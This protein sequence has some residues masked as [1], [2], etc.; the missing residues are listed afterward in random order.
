MSIDLRGTMTPERQEEVAKALGMDSL[1]VPDYDDLPDVH[2]GEAARQAFN[3]KK[4]IACVDVLASHTFMGQFM[5][6]TIPIDQAMDP[7]VFKRGWSQSV[8]IDTSRPIPVNAK[9][10]AVTGITRERKESNWYGWLAQNIQWAFTESGARAMSPVLIFRARG[11]KRMGKWLSRPIIGAV[12][13]LDRTPRDGVCMSDMMA[14]VGVL[15][16]STHHSDN[17]VLPVGIDSR[18]VESD[19]HDAL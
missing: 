17:K 11:E 18:A 19:S 15:H 6:S 4:A 14:S 2:D 5:P 12:Y 13:T 8:V 10:T 16:R 9:I 7:R 1:P 3:F